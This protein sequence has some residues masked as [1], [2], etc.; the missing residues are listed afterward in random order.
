MPEDQVT[1]P[2]GSPE[3]PVLDISSEDLA[4]EAPPPAAPPVPEQA[5][6]AAPAKPHHDDQEVTIV[7]EPPAPAGPLVPETPP[8]LVMLEPVP[9]AP[10]AVPTPV[11]YEQ[12]PA[13]A[14]LQVVTPQAIA[15]A[16]QPATYVPSV[17]PAPTPVMASD[18]WYTTSAGEVFGPYPAADIRAWLTSGQVSWDTQASRGAGDT[19]RPLSQIA[20]FNP[21]PSYGAPVGAVAATPGNKDKTIAGILGILLGAFGAHHWYLGNYMLAGIYLGVTV[22]TL[23]MLSF[24]PAIAGLVEGIMYLTAPDDKF[25]RN[26]KKWFLAGP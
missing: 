12:P 1:P 17:Q 3:E 10:M 26:Y 7:Q 9:P 4:A 16:A 18:Q 13:P 2:P 5:L 11:A 15:P 22:I 8:A 21:A 25:Q 24:A 23:G 20:E 14:V 19:W 6:P